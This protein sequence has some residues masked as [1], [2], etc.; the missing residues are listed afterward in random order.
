MVEDLLPRLP[1]DERRD[2]LRLQAYPEGTAG[3]EMTTDFAKL[4]ESLTVREA[5]AELGRQAEEL[6]TIYYLYVVDASDHL[7]GVVSARQLVSAMGKVDTKLGDI[8]ETDVECCAA[9]DELGRW[10]KGRSLRL[11]RDSRGRSAAPDAGII[12][13]DDVI[14]VVVEEAAEDAYAALRSTRLENSYLKTSLLTLS[15]KRGIWLT[16]LFFAALLTAM[17]INRYEDRLNAVA[18]LVLFIPLVISSGGTRA[19][20]RD[21]DHHRAAF[22]RYSAQRLGAGLAT[23]AIHGN[24][25]WKD[26]W[27][28]SDSSPLCSKRRPTKPS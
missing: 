21:A 5:L 3:A 8:M 24:C 11:A 23:R 28:P 1:V 9:S 27:R 13:H 25:C 20:S 17:A 18:W 10:C 12:T 4:S 26:S 14:D 15:W 7:L 19:A 2:I 6:E 16:I 22:G